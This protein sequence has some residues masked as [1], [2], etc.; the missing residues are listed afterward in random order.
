M[1][2]AIRQIFA[3]A[4]AA[5][6]TIAGGALSSTRVASSGTSVYIPQLDST[7]WSGSLLAYP[8]TYDATVGSV[9]KA[10][11]PA[12]SAGT[13]PRTNRRRERSTRS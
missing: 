7:R 8:L 4:G 3:K 12:W 9:R 10:D 1:I 6:G 13:L 5:S 11:T 2:A